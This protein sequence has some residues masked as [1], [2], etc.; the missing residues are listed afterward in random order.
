MVTLILVDLPSHMLLPRFLRE[1]EFCIY[2][3][4]R[5][6]AFEK[7]GSTMSVLTVLWLRTTDLS[8]LQGTVAP[9]SS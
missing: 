4:H 6:E 7:A 5:I 2:R 1:I 3:S 9:S 8:S